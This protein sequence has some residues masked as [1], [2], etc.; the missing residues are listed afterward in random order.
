MDKITEEA[1]SVKSSRAVRAVLDAR[2]LSFEDF[3]L[4]SDGRKWQSVARQRR[5]LFMEL[6][7]YANSDGSA[8]YASVSTMQRCSGSER[9]TFRR[10]DELKQLGLLRDEGKSRFQGTT[11]RSVLL[12]DEDDE[13]MTVEELRK[14]RDRRRRQDRAGILL[15]DGYR[16]WEE[17]SRRDYPEC[18]EKLDLDSPTVSDSPNSAILPDS[19]TKTENVSPNQEDASILPDS[20]SDSPIL[21][22]RTSMLPDSLP[23]LPDRRPILPPRWHPTV[24]TDRPSDRPSDREPTPREITTLLCS[25]CGQRMPVAEYAEHEC[26]RKPTGKPE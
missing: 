1:N 16:L 3:R 17:G 8:I 26:K 25:R 23:M 20:Q 14:L 18:W 10:L 11:V 5:A 7:S 21:P 19:Q 6:C 9:T 15:P 2:A 4:P 12:P 22:D 13:R 24:L